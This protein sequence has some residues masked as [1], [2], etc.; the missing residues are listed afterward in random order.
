MSEREKA[1]AGAGMKYRR[2][3]RLWKIRECVK[4]AKLELPANAPH[5]RFGNKWMRHGPMA[6]R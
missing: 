6:G 1:P 2:R 4:A 3:I 5:E